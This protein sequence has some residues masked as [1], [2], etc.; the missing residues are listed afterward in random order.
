MT[1]VCETATLQRRFIHSTMAFLPTP[2]A[3]LSLPAFKFF[4]TSLRVYPPI[5]H[6]PVAAAGPAAASGWRSV[7]HV[8]GQA[9]EL[10]GVAP[11]HHVL[12]K[13]GYSMRRRESTWK[14]KVT[15]VTLIP[16]TSWGYFTFIHQDMF[17]RI[18][19]A[20]AW[21][22]PTYTTSLLPSTRSR[23]L[24]LAQ[25]VGDNKG[26]VVYSLWLAWWPTP[27]SIWPLTGW[28]IMS[29][30]CCVYLSQAVWNFTHIGPLSFTLV[31]SVSWCL[32]KLLYST[33]LRAYSYYCNSFQFPFNVKMAY[34]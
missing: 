18:H 2:V 19:L 1:N 6:S 3:H 9:V 14:A 24:T 30:I 5:K 17:K 33:L 20:C 23:I 16:V 15:E 34:W 4:R 32:A 26:K 8:L 27:P 13:V 31:R 10:H 7:L 22:L 28:D 11:R 21:S 12:V 25:L 29:E